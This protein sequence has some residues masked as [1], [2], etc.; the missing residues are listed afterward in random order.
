[1]T[2]KQYYLSLLMKQD[3]AWVF[4]SMNAPSPKM[5]YVDIVLHKIALKRMGYDYTG[6]KPCGA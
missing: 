2:N 1:M 4:D 5:T 6:G 3:P